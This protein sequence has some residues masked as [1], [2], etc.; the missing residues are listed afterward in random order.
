MDLYW[1]LRGSTGINCSESVSPV[2]FHRDRLQGNSLKIRIN[3]KLQMIINQFFNVYIVFLVSSYGQTEYILIK[4]LNQK[5]SNLD[6]GC[7]SW[8]TSHLYYITCDSRISSN[9]SHNII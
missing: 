9:A 3:I 1:T 8:E 2:V 5:L 4:C 7:I 6:I